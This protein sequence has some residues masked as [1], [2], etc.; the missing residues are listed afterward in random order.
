MYL[1]RNFY[2]RKKESLTKTANKKL[3]AEKLRRES[4]AFSKRKL[5]ETKSEGIF[6]TESVQRNLYQKMFEKKF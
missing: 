3:S 6:V 5:Y 1:K 4:F 2:Q